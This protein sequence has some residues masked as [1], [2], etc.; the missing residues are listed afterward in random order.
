MALK[1]RK[2]EYNYIPEEQVQ[3]SPKYVPAPKRRKIFAP[4]EKFLAVVFSAAIIMFS[5]TVLHTQAQ[6]NETNKD[7]F[8]LTNNIENVSKQNVELSNQVS[9]K[10]TYE[11]VWGK[12]KELGLN[13][14]ESNVKVVSGR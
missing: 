3:D 9:E 2:F 1:Q 6:I 7:I 14:N 8:Y 5:T 13:L 4:G 12:A 11:R 10:S